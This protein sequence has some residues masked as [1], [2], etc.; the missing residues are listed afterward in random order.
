VYI[1]RLSSGGQTVNFKWIITTM[2]AMPGI[3]IAVI[4]L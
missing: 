3:L 2:L 4:K 1:Y